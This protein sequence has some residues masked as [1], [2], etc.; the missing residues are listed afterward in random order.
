LAWNNLAAIREREGKQNE[1]I[2]H[3]RK[4]ASLDPG[5]T[6]DAR[7]NLAK[8][9]FKAGK[10]EEAIAVYHQLDDASAYLQLAGWF[11][12]Q[13]RIAE[14]IEVLERAIALK[15]DLAAA[16]H[17]L[18]VMVLKSGRTRDAFQSLRTA[19]R[20]A[21]GLASARNILG[22]ALL[23]NGD[24]EESIDSIIEAIQLE[25]GSEPFKNALLAALLSSGRI[26][27]AGL[28]HGSCDDAGCVLTL[29]LEKDQQLREI[30]EKDGP[31]A[32]GLPALLNDIYELFS[33]SSYVAA[34]PRPYSDAELRA[35]WDGRREEI[36]KRLASA[37]LRQIQIRKQS[38]K[39]PG[40]TEEELRAIAADVL[41]KLIEGGDFATL[42][43]QHSDGWAEGKTETVAYGELA[44]D[45]NAAAFSLGEGGFTR[46]VIEDEHAFYLLKV[47]SRQAGKVEAFD[48][49]KAQ[50]A[51]KAVLAAQSR[52]DW[53]RRYLAYLQDKKPDRVMA[54]M[55]N[56]AAAYLM[57]AGDFSKAEKLLEQAFAM[58]LAEL[59]T[60]DPKTL[61]T[62][63]NLAICRLQLGQAEEAMK[64]LVELLAIR[65]KVLGPEHPDTLLAMGNLAHCH[66]Q[67][68]RREDAIQLQEQRLTLSRK[69]SGP[70]HS[71]TLAAMSVLGR[72]YFEVGRQED[73]LKLKTESEAIRSKVSGQ[74]QDPK[75]AA[76]T[77]LPAPSPGSAVAALKDGALQA[78][79]GK[80]AEH[81]AT[82]RR[83]L[84][85][86]AATTNADVA[87]RVAKLACL[88]P[89]ADA[90]TQEA[91]LTLAR[92][93]LEL[94][95]ASGEA[96]P[97]QQMTLG[98]AEY[99]GGRFQE[100]DFA[101]NAVAGMMNPKTY[102]PGVIQGTADCYRSMSLFHQGRKDEARALVAATEAKMK[103]FPADEQN[104]L[105]RADHDDL[106]LWL[107]CREAKALLSPKEN[108]NSPDNP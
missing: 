66:F 58:Q 55:Q 47:E 10:H 43:E 77:T 108:L 103:P 99:R 104:P 41:Q 90:K 80:D 79:S 20:L 5:K 72:C 68:G 48:D 51:I 69:V 38:D 46:K 83:M 71:Q 101:L 31:E 30:L 2:E 107:A 17:D 97:W 1:A 82:R 50:E 13:E 89:I 94:A 8:T 61:N 3:F 85:G 9:L 22:L 100:A 105:A 86:A 95:R 98:M 76:P 91:A 40:A 49:P 88:R 27:A 75:P 14:A 35:V 56:M 93:A 96:G 64:M 60:E 33:R 18:G 87:E 11:E 25:P 28:A 53:E 74:R 84:A 34:V 23:T 29:L 39:H 37:T 73:A 26:T 70:E 92:K 102:R 4:A 36:D 21:P 42:A 6:T 32:A 78:W 12:K 44:A 59:G 65:R 67:A 7:R 52:G 45:L 19:V 81:D 106:I 57:A 15:P 16:H 54:R 24:Y 62:M 63:G